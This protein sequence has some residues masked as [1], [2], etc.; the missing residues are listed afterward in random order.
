MGRRG[1]GLLAGR[2]F[3]KLHRQVEVRCQNLAGRIWTEPNRRRPV[4]YVPSWL[5]FEEIP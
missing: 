5:V 1:N 4:R 2:L 3:L